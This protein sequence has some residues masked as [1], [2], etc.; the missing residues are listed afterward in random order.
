MNWT[1]EEAFFAVS[2]RITSSI[3]AFVFP[4]SPSLIHLT[5]MLI[6]LFRCVSL[7]SLPALLMFCCCV[8]L[9]CTCRCFCQALL[10]LP[11]WE[12]GQSSATP[13]PVATWYS[14]HEI[15]LSTCEEGDQRTGNLQCDAFWTWLRCAHDFPVLREGRC[16][17]KQT[18]VLVQIWVQWPHLVGQ[19]WGESACPGNL[20][21]ALRPLLLMWSERS[22][23]KGWNPPGSESWES[24]QRKSEQRKVSIMSSGAKV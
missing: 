15:C 7:P 9:L 13:P 21:P 11:A 4:K 19:G 5:N 10:C 23:R 14:S 20:P 18:R 17:R 6:N 8:L 24:W 2:S 12:M 3:L 1:R 16:D 22:P